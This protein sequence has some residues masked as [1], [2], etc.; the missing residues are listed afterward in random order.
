MRARA[1]QLFGYGRSDRS[2]K[3]TRGL[4]SEAAAGFRSRQGDD[5]DRTPS[6][7]TMLF[8]RHTRRRQFIACSAMRRL[9][10]LLPRGR[11]KPAPNTSTSQS[12]EPSACTLLALTL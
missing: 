4:I 3:L 7:L 2:S 12:G 6:P 1:R 10:G 11:D 5:H 9:G 8:S